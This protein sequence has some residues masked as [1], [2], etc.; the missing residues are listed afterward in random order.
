MLWIVVS[1]AA[2]VRAESPAPSVHWGAL[3]YPDQER[4]LDAGLTINRFTEFGPNGKTHYN[5]IRE[6]DGFNFVTLSWTEKWNKFKGFDT[7]LTIGAG[8]TRDQP[9]R[10]F[11]NDVAHGIFFP[12]PLVPVAATRN[13]T[14]YMLSGAVTKWGELF[15][16]PDT[17]Y[18]GVGVATGTL[19]QEGFGRLGVRRL[20]LDSLARTVTG[21]DLAGLQF[22]SQFVRFS[23]MA[24][25][26]RL[27]G[28]SVYHS[29]TIAANSYLGQVSVSLANYKDMEPGDPPRWELEIGYTI[30]SGLFVN[31]NG[32]SIRERFGSLTIR[33]P[34]GAFELWD[35]FVQGTDI[36]PTY[37]ARLM[38]DVLRL[39]NRLSHPCSC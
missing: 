23:A 19:Y 28:G 32:D 4:T 15:G 3:G 30:D 14:D 27:A 39:Y 13:A 31:P 12:S 38:F 7:N 5:A 35:D 2:V 25:Y 29:S 6:T 21:R 36:G 33:F 22:I 1:C 24:R 18:V 20:A 34:Y 26:G 9:S 37:G 17:G 16:Q 11:Q 8:P 10:Y